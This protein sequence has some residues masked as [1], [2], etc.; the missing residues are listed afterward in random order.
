MKTENEHGHDWWLGLA[1]ILTHGVVHGAQKLER[2][3]LSIA[4][5]TFNV[6]ER[7][8]VTRPWSEAVRATHHSVSRLSYRSVSAV[9]QGAGELLR[10]PERN[11]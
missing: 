8:P 3:H 4:D 1:D 7:I 6:L 11:R 2:V 10:G 5:E 9:A